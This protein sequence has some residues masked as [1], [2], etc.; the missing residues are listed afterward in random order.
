MGRLFRRLPNLQPIQLGS[1]YRRVRPYNTEE[2]ATVLAIENDACGIPHVRFEVSLGNTD[3]SLLWD[4][5]RVLALQSFAEQYS[6]AAASELGNRV[7]TLDREVE[8]LRPEPESGKGQGRALRLASPEP[9]PQPV[10]GAELLDKIVTTLNRYLALPK[11]GAEAMALWVLHAHAHQ[12]ADFAPRLA[13]TS[14]LPRCGKTTALTLI[15]RMVPRP[16]LASNLTAPV[17]FRVIEAAKP[18]LI[19]DEADTFMKTNDE[20]RGVLNSGHTR[21]AAYVVRN[22][23]DGDDH[24]PHKF[25]TWAA[26]VVAMIGRLPATLE[27]RSIVVPMQRRAPDKQVERLRRDRFD[28]LAEITSM[29]ARWAADNLGDLIGHEP[30]PLDGLHDRAADNWEPLFSIADLAGG[31]WPEQARKA[32]MALS[33]NIEEALPGPQLLA[34]IKGLFEEH[35]TDRLPSAEI[36][37]ALVAM[38]DRPWAEWG[39]RN[40]KPITPNALARQLGKY[41]IRP[42]PRRR[43]VDV[44]KGY[45]LD[46]FQDAFSR[47]L[48]PALS[49]DTPCPTVTR[50]QVKESAGLSDLPT[51][52]RSLNVTVTNR[53]KAPEIMGCNRVT[54]GMGGED[55]GVPR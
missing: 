18:T 7:T 48:P 5:S 49:Q 2:T 40:S 53:P 17:V 22:V 47:Y 24:E 45:L 52:T 23:A 12:A 42:K 50:L 1:I 35:R 54:D 27:D 4:N 32:A 44:F 25:S 36:C 13:F 10:D 33:G 16:L 55:G 21:D 51:V 28:E 11:S 19:I 43:G 14:P 6:D 38:E 3:R 9:W 20:L 26:V 39:K 46:E 41:N 29:A 15:G 30:A 8:L 37:E 31:N 34:D